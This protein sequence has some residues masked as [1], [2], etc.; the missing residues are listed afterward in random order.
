MTEAN[1]SRTMNRSAHVP[2]VVRRSLKPH[3]HTHAR[4]TKEKTR[5]APSYCGKIPVGDGLID[6]QQQNCWKNER[7]MTCTD[8]LTEMVKL[9]KPRLSFPMMAKSHQQNP[10]VIGRIQPMKHWVH[11]LH[12]TEQ[13]VKQIRTMPATKMDVSF[14]A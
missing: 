2:C 13:S 3:C 8:F 5:D 11:A 4:T 1:C 9:T 14:Q 7:L 12:A 6:K 10:P